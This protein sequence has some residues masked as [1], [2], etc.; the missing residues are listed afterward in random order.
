MRLRRDEISEVLGKSAHLESIQG[1]AAATPSKIR[2]HVRFFD[3]LRE[4][5][6]CN[7][8]PCAYM[9]SPLLTVIS[10]SALLALA[11]VHVLASEF[12]LYWKYPWL[13]MPVHVLGGACVALSVALIISIGVR[14]PAVCQRVWGVL[15]MVLVVGLVWEVF[16]CMFG[17]M[18]IEA[19]YVTDALVDLGMDLFGGLIGYI[20]V[21]NIDT[22]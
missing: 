9:R 13:D 6:V 17:I 1:H 3:A 18:H 19:G 22:L 4:G 12:Y 7:V 16:E 10:L 15:G 20:L 21:R 2:T 5:A 14:V 8:V 11:L